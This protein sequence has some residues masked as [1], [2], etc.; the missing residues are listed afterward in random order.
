[1]M[2][3]MEV[4]EVGGSP[5]NDRGVVVTASSIRGQRMTQSESLL[6]KAR[7]L[8]QHGAHSMGGKL[9]ERRIQLFFF[10]F[11]LWGEVR[12]KKAYPTHLTTSDKH[13]T[14][15]YHSLTLFCLINKMHFQLRS[16]SPNLPLTS[17]PAV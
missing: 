7:Y 12:D 14:P 10:F 16:T 5:G 6:I 3:V 11:A 13:A 1:M 2:E 4:M 8:L 17:S 15:Y 9:E